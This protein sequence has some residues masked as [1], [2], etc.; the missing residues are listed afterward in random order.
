MLSYGYVFIRD[1]Q[2]AE[3]PFSMDLYHLFQSTDKK[4]D[5]W[6]NLRMFSHSDGSASTHPLPVAYPGG[7]SGCPETP[8]PGH[9]FFNLPRPTII[10]MHF[11]CAKQS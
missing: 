4:T 5:L 9:D 2:S 10:I 8:P 3:N 6:T 7:F 1:P 11:Q